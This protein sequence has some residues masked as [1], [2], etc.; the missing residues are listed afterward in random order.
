MSK[1]FKIVLVL[2]VIA[3][4]VS[5]ALAVILYMDKE[6]EYTKR[7]MLE[8][9]LAATLKEKREIE[10][11]MDASKKLAEETEAKLSEAEA[12]LEGLTAQ[13]EEAEEKSKTAKEDLEIKEKEVTKLK[14]DIEKEKKEKLTISKKLES[15][16]ADYDKA[17]M[18]VLRIKKENEMLEKDLSGLKEK[19]VEL[20]TI[21][22]K[23]PLK[24]VSRPEQEESSM[25]FLNGRI[26]VV[27]K[28]YNFVVTDLGEDDGIRK[29]MVI[30]IRDGNEFLG[31]A[32]V[33]KV[34]ET[35]SS[36]TMLP[37][38][39]INFVKKGNTVIESP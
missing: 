19:T 33:D 21:V 16:Q 35:M 4:I 20:D 8:D 14:E 22:V 38:G 2:L 17:K 7:L 34:Y 18:D 3:S 32:E 39:K 28:D 23:P 37:G 29:G 13:V 9:K 5:A 25:E 6:R 10:K 1:I 24:T 31:K 12:K 27:N 30:E 15:L 11:E 36:A 26:L